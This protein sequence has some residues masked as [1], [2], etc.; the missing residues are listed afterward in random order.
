M[1]G[2]CPKC[3]DAV[4]EGENKYF[5]RSN[6]CDFQ[7]GK[8]ILEQ[9]INQVQAAKLLS[10]RRTDVLDGFI[11]KSGKPFPA[12]LVMDNAGKITFEFPAQEPDADSENDSDNSAEIQ[13][14]KRS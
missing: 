10:H 3:G 13:N 4:V 1:I 14:A 11:S 12:Y 8:K 6:D 7:F 9:P 5:C 2:T